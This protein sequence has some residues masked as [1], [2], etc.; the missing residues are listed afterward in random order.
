MLPALGDAVDLLHKYFDLQYH[1]GK[2]LFQ[3][4][5]SRLLKFQHSQTDNKTRYVPALTRKYFRNYS[6]SK[7]NRSPASQPDSGNQPIYS[8]Y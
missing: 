1:D 3:D 2:Q 8:Y 5:P 6:K 7:K 4:D